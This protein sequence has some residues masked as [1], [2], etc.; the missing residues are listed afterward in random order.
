M[1]QRLIKKVS[2]TV[3]QQFPEMKGCSPRIEQ[4]QKAQAKS[5]RQKPI[6]LLVYKT[7]SLDPLGR[8]IPR[9]VRV[10]ANDRGKI[11]RIS[12]SR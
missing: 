8:K 2:K 3:Y 1:N 5:L 9:Q 4:N 7:I 6:F 10:T 11:L 12:T